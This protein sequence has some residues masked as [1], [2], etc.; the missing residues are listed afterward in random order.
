MQRKKVILSAILTTGVL[1]LSACI[2]LLPLE[3]DPVTGDYGPD[4][5]SQEHQLR[6]FDELW[7]NFETAYIYF[8]SAEQDWEGLR[9]RYTRRIESGLSSAEFNSM[10]DDLEADLPPRSLIHQTRQE[11]LEA[12]LAQLETYDGIGAF[13][14]FQAEDVPHAVIL[15]VMEGS[16]AED[17]GL[18]AHDS[19]FSIDG[20]PILLEEGLN[21][22]SRIRGPAGTS[23]TLE[24]RSPGQQQRTIDVERARLT[25]TG[26]LEASVVPST[27]YVYLLFPPNGYEGLEQDVLNSLEALA[28]DRELAGLILD[29]RIASSSRGWPIETLF[30][31][32][33][34]GEIGEL[35][36][37]LQA[38]PVEIQGQDVFNS[39]S[40][41]LVILVGENTSGF[42]EVLAASL[43]MHERAT[44]IGEPTPGDVE[45]QSSFF[46]PDGS[47][48]F[49]ESTSFR[50]PDGMDIG[51]SGVEPDIR[52][53]AGW[54][55]VLPEDDPVLEQAV[56]FLETQE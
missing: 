49:V 51:T 35:Y 41:P 45:T 46:L 24:V 25:S 23:V 37:R 29:L 9:E 10:L 14:G 48:M 4:F 36:N 6:T 52:V 1:F 50:L 40:V 56:T 16:P 42:A 54:D 28:P 44:L 21:A 38:Q 27:E 30:S 3:E 11:R 55:D 53:E 32:F 19:I 43:Q 2:G 12:D 13:I 15:A 5:A 26:K 8:E 47:R 33:H 20:I 18:K 31:M 7:E 22:V 17:A 34:E 39:Q